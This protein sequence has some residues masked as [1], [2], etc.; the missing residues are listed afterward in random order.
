[1][2]EGHTIHRL[3]RDHRKD[4]VDR[5]VTVG[6][7]QGRFTQ[8]AAVL[9]GRVLTGVDAYGKHLFYRWGDDTLHVHLGLFGRFMRYE[10]ARGAPPEPTPTTRLR[11]ITD[12]VTIHLS[13]PTVCELMNPVAEDALRAR[14][15]PDLLG[16]RPNADA[17]F[18]ALQRRRSAIGTVLLDQRVL[19]G[20][21]NVYRAEA[22]FLCGIH[23]DT[24]ANAISRAH[25]DLLWETLRQ[26][27]R[28]GV[29]ANRIVT[30][31]PGD[32][33]VTTRRQLTEDQ[34]LYVYRRAGEPCRRCGTT[35]T[36]WTLSARA[37]YACPSCQPEQAV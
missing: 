31:E 13:G 23:P 29:A 25:F 12:A 26:Q 15:G 4:L 1:V 22:L 30:V 6:S 9:N 7:P 2:P 19:V 20:V 17:V 10:H 5:S 16:R 28:A 37:I 3:A 8:G 18:D 35:I 32:V 21:G 14:L 33:G 27:L 11:L 34:R 24:P 36:S